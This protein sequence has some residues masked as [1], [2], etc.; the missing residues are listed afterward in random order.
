M[1]KLFYEGIDGQACTCGLSVL[2]SHFGDTSAVVFIQTESL[3]ASITRSIEKIACVALRDV[4][5]GLP[6]D[7]F[8]FFEYY[9]P[10]FKPP[11]IWQ[12]V[13]FAGVQPVYSS[14]GA[15]AQF[16][17]KITKEKPLHFSV[18]SP[19]WLSVDRSVQADL[20]E[21]VEIEAFA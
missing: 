20:F 18:R 4:L 12:E 16:V 19:R 13:Q 9:P 21:H 14:D 3:G 10:R 6:V 7:G 5:P 11:V 8:R 15:F 2:P 17:R 1:K